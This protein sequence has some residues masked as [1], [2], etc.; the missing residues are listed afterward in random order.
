M[1]KKALNII[2][3]VVAVV[4][5]LQT[6]SVI[7]LIYATKNR[8]SE[9]VF[10]DIMLLSVREGN[11]VNAKVGSL[12]IVDMATH[13]KG[14]DYAA[15]LGGSVRLSKDPMANIGTV[16]GY[17]PFFGSYLDFLRQSIGFF[18]IIILPLFIYVV[19][20]SVRLILLLRDRR[21]TDD[22]N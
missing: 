4:L 7:T 9:P 2:I 10:G 20:Y 21:E 12:A 1:K 5:L 16:K 11:M 8:F 3:K 15:F 14:S 18:L 13:D 6:I 19:G 17:I 22:G